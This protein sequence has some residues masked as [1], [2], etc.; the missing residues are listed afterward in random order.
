[1]NWTNLALHSNFSDYVPFNPSTDLV[2][3][4]LNKTS[5][6]QGSSYFSSFTGFS[7]F[8]PL[9][10]ANYTDTST[11]IGFPGILV[12]YELSSDSSTSDSHVY[13]YTPREGTCYNRTVLY[14]YGR[15]P[16]QLSWNFTADAADI[17]TLDNNVTVSFT[18]CTDDWYEAWETM[19]KTGGI[20]GVRYYL[21]A[22]PRD[23]LAVKARVQT[24]EYKPVVI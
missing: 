21:S 18:G 23:V 8:T 24:S 19:V 10:T 2:Q 3:Y 7:I 22:S 1:M 20:A 9:Y 14:Q 5:S 13:L 11:F 4:R 17:L 16:Q 15:V 12:Y 6:L